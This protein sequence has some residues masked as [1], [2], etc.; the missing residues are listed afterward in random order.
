MPQKSSADG[1]A[2]QDVVTAVLTASRVLVGVAARSLAEVED[3]V[4]VTQ[5]RPL[6]LL[7]SRGEM[8][9]QALAQL[10]DVNPSTALRTVDRLEAAG[11]VT[12]VT[13][14]ANRREVLLD[15]SA[16]G[17]RLVR[18]VTSRRRQQIERVVSSLEQP[19][20]DALVEALGAFAE[21]AGEP[22]A[23]PDD[24]SRMGW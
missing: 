9:L 22:P 19:Q 11:L 6:V 8:N 17:R 2:A 16:A 3:T 4:T 5:F 23:G 1:A 24:L 18:Q 13:N 7:D 20:R 14:P 12:R 15:V 10:L 21:A